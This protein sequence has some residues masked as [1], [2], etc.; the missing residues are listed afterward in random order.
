MLVAPGDEVAAEDPLVTL[1]SDK[2]TMEVPSPR[3]RHGRRLKVAVGD[4][5]SEGSLILHAR[6]RPRRTAPEPPTRR[7]PSAGRGAGS[8]EPPDRAD[9]QRRR[10]PCSAPGPAATRRRSAPPTS[11]SVALVDR[12]EPLGGVCLNV[13]CIPSKALLHVAR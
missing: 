5:V 8:P 1:E 9:V 3:R 7:P 11:G 4:K 13:G 12:G 6:D 10:S 2:A